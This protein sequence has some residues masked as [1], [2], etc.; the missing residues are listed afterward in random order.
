LGTDSMQFFNWSFDYEKGV[1]GFDLIPS[2]R[3]L[4]FNRQEQSIHAIDETETTPP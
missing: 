4:L 3:K 2:K 1:C